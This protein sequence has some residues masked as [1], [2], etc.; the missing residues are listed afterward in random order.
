MDLS[1][2][3]WRRPTSQR[4]ERRNWVEVASQ[5]PDVVAVRDSKDTRERL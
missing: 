1:S 3:R 5:L 4:R 2:A